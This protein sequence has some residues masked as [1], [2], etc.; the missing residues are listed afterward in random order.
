MNKNAFKK[1]TD[2]RGQ[3][4]RGLWLRN[5][6]FIARLAIDGRLKWIPLSASTPAEA[7]T[8]LARVQLE[9]LDNT[10]R[11]IGRAPSFSD[12]LVTYKS[13]LS[14]S[15]KK[16]DT[17]LLEGYS[18]DRWALALGSLS[19]DKLRPSHISNQ[20][21]KLRLSGLSP[22]TCNLALT[23]LRNLLHSARLDG[24]IKTSPADGLPWMKTDKRSRTLYTR[25]DI[26]LIIATALKASKNGQQLSDFL[27]LLSLAGSREQETLCLTW[28]DVDFNRA[29]L[30]IGADGNS[31]NREPRRV[32]FNPELETLL[33]L[34]QER[35]APDSQFLFP[36]PQRGSLSDRRAFTF[37]ESLLLTRAALPPRLKSF[38]FHDCRHHFISYAVMSGIDFMTIARWVG[39]KDGGLLIGKVYGHLSN[40]HTK[41]QAARLSFGPPSSTTAPGQAASPN[42][43]A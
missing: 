35:R 3:A 26:D 10:L 6:K 29:L 2:N 28:S 24:F 7:K 8:E 40:E 20:L 4:I 13:R 31:K 5:G 11:H 39:H 23:I 9:K 36:S 37:R 38:G 22:R 27:R 25:A 43:A 32:D 19:L 1:V 30:T 18:L 17:I 33:L 15:G 14:T 12:Y 21:H 41:S 42:L 34:M 16:P